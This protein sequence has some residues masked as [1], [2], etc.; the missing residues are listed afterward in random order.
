MVG[1]MGNEIERAIYS[2]YIPSSVVV[3]SDGN[4]SETSTVELLTDRAMVDGLPTV[5]VCENF[6]CQRPVTTVGE[7]TELLAS[8]VSKP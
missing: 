1:P 6:V 5:Y 3:R 2:S 4:S 7:L 8:S